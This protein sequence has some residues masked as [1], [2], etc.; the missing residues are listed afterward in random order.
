MSF[1]I[2][3]INTDG[4]YLHVIRGFVVCKYKD[5]SEKR[6][7]ISDLKLLVLATPQVSFSNQC[8]ARMLE[9]NI[10]VLHCAENY[11]PI[12][13][14]IGLDQVVRTEAF[15]NQ[16]SQDE[17]FN[18]SLWSKIC[19]Q[20]IYNQ[21]DLLGDLGISLEVKVSDN[22]QIE[23]PRIARLY[24]ERFF[25][26][27]TRV[28]NRERRNAESFENKALNY[29]YA[30]IKTLIY[31]AVLIHGLLPS[32][33]I[34]HKAKF[35]GHALVYDLIEPWRPF[36][37]LLFA[38][39]AIQQAEKI[40]KYISDNTLDDADE[41]FNMWIQFFMNGLVDYKLKDNNCLFKLSDFLDMYILSIMKSFEGF[42]LKN[43]RLPILKNY[44][45]QG[46]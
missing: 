46:N 36:V 18:F 27:V 30:V 38:H 35:H 34:N 6:I 37:D 32:L 4:A 5:L 3:T 25:G 16:I 10:S 24:W 12:G 31:R 43:L 13:W 26:A 15:L 19:F 22:P 1:H 17:K 42:N 45:N 44:I 11:Q 28:L 8:L 21:L 7:P 23:E 41:L 20:K 2:L 40:D 29:G 33:G 39:F 9:N 14:T